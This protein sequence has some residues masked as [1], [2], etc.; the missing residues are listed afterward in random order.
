MVYIESFMQN[1]GLRVYKFHK[2]GK[3]SLIICHPDKTEFNFSLLLHGHVDVVHGN[4]SQYEIEVK[5]GLIHGRGCLDMKGSIAVFL[6]LME[7]LFRE[8]RLPLGMGLMLTSDEEQ[9][10]IN[11]TKFLFDE[12]NIQ[13]DF[14]IT[15]EPTDLHIVNRH[16]G[17]W[18]TE[19]NVSGLSAHSSTPWLGDNS[20]HKI[21][22]SIQAF[23]LENPPVHQ[24][25]WKSTY[26]FNRL[27]SGDSLNKIPEKSTVW[28]DIRYT[29]EEELLKLTQSI[30]RNFSGAEINVL[31]TSP[32]FHTEGDHGRITQ[33]NKVIEGVVGTQADI[34]SKEYATD[35]RYAGV[36]K[37]PA[38][39]FGPIGKGLHEDDEYVELAS[40]IKYYEILDKF[41]TQ[42]LHD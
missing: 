26:S 6:L 37:I 9:G 23:M 2:N 30:E 3:P 16:K 41:C 36:H 13:A 25:E 15:G 21:V 39:V 19:I 14:F 33:L 40:L 20:L 7:V 38:I 5:E 24:E 29:T 35:A 31:F 12:K 10:G 32:P 42:Y 18:R 4:E 34:L 22:Q 8:G 28:V 11:G 1:A 17:V 27:D